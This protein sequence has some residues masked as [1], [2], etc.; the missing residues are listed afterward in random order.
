MTQRTLIA[1]LETFFDTKAKYSLKHLSPLEY[2]RDPRFKVH[3]AAFQ[4]VDAGEA[5]WVPHEDLEP[6]LASVDW[7]NTALV[8]HNANFDMTVFFEKYGVS[9]ARRIDTLG[10]CRALLPRDLDFDLDS[11]A[12]LL[13]ITGK[14]DG[15]AALKAVDGVRDPSPQQLAALGHYA[16]QDIAITLRAFNTLWPHL[17]ET[18]RDVMNLVIRLST[19]GVLECDPAILD[20]AEQEILADRQAKLDR[21]GVAPEVLRSRDQFAA[22]LR[23]HGVEPPT[24]ISP[25]T[26]KETYAFSLQDP[27][28]IA[29]RANPK[30]APL[31]TARMAVASNNAITRVRRFK[32]ITSRAPHTLPM[33]LN[34]NG[35]HTGRLSGGGKINTQNLNARGVGKKLRH[36]IRAPKDHVIVVRDQSGIELRMN[37]WFSGQHDVLDLIRN[38]GDVYILEAARQFNVAPHTIDK[39]TPDGAQKRQFGKVVQLGCGFQMGVDRFINFCAAGPLGMDPIYLTALQASHTIQTYRLNH[40]MVKASWDWLQ[41]I[42]L[43]L[44]LDKNAS[45]PRGPVLIEHEGIRLPNGL[46]LEYPALEA[47]EDGWQWGLTDTKHR[48]Y[49][50]IMQENCVQALAGVLIKEQMVEIQRELDAVDLERRA[51]QQ[52]L[53]DTRQLQRHLQRYGQVV[54]QVHDEILV[55]CH[56]RDADDVSA[57]MDKVMSTPRPWAPDLPLAVEG[58]YAEAYTK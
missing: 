50:G 28:F 21:A 56:Q 45:E 17:P 54:H 22:L 34:Y 49:G 12:K 6:F 1:D 51:K 30:V 35:A 55:V 38:G 14:A 27:E 24:K 42:A 20:E 33:L 25:A 7:P 47:T 46:R 53:H 11:L 39:N 13:G 26:G 8:T 43:P 58:G 16:C 41:Y 57:L 44:M 36:A 52:L 10:L 37:M 31:V 40:P 3:G 9:P 15:S 18:E 2:I 4:W 19:E 23:E 32:A 48:I 29:L 5:F